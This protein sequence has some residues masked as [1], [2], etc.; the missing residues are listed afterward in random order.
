MTKEFTEEEKA[1]KLAEFR[2]ALR[3]AEPDERTLQGEDALSDD[4]KTEIAAATEKYRGIHATLTDADCFRFL[5]ARNYV[6]TAAVEMALHWYVWFNTTLADSTFSPR[7]M[8]RRFFE[9][10]DDKECFYQE[11][12]PHAN[13]GHDKEGRPIYWEKTGLISSR[14][15]KIKA[16][17]NDN[18]LF[19]RCVCLCM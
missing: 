5:R 16:H 4:Q 1:T 11:L 14:F 13:L 17:F 8:R 10:G 12:M 19:N 6:I 18:D 9:E 15:A 7:D 2:K 3:E